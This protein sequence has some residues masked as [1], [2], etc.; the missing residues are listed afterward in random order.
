[1]TIDVQ[2]PVTPRDLDDS[3]QECAESQEGHV[4][5]K[6]LMKVKLTS[7]FRM[8]ILSLTWPVVFHQGVPDLA[9]LIEQSPGMALLVA[10]VG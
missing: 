8:L 4:M 6:L 3:R 2:K 9:V 5:D 7:F 10:E 1:M